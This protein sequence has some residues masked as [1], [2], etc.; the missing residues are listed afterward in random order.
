MQSVRLSYIGDRKYIDTSEG[1]IDSLPH[2]GT[3]LEN[4]VLQI[5]ENI[6]LQVM[7]NITLQ[8]CS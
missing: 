8:S 1:C 7:E 5:L 3:A 2:R 4:I 6:M